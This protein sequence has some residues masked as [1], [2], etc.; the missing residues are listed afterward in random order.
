MSIE[1]VNLAVAFGGG[2]LSFFSPCIVPL[3]PGYLSYLAGVGLAD[4]QNNPSK[5]F[6]LR[7][8]FHALFFVIGFS[9]VFIVLGGFF[10]FIGQTVVTIKPWLQRVG[11]I[12]IILFGLYSLRLIK[13]PFLD[14]DYQITVPSA[15]KF[16]LAGA[17]AIGAAFALGWTPCIGPILYAILILASTETSVASGAF[18]LTSYAAGLAIPFLA[19]GLFTGYFT[20]FIKSANR[21][22]NW[23]NI[24]AGVILIG[25]GIA[26]FTDNLTKLINFLTGSAF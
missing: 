17:S 5:L 14:A 20:R 7:V 22:F 25:I 21:F 3:V 19:A 11:G 26:I 6:Q 8:F 18:L 1:S 9:I 12:V 13:L 15:S 2:L 23:V 4:V 24:V 10:G 16:R